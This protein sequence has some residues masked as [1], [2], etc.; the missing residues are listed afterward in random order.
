VRTRAGGFTLD[1]A[2]DLDSLRFLAGAGRAA[3][4]VLPAARALGHVPEASLDAVSVSKLLHGQP[5]PAPAGFAV[6]AGSAVR[7]TDP[8][9]RLV[10]LGRLDAGA[11]VPL[12]LL[13]AGESIA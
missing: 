4:A 9:G 8:S 3:E 5:A 12:R 11:L 1:E 2:V 13:P 7:L 10:G 6:E